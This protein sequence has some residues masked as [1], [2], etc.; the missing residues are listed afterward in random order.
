M[1]FQEENIGLELVYV[2]TSKIDVKIKK[3]IVYKHP[4][5]RRYG[6]NN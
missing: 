1:R 2:G 6:V 4:E 3:I 5:E